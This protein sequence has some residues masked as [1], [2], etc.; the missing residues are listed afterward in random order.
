MLIYFQM[1]KLEINKYNVNFKLLHFFKVV[2]GNMQMIRFWVIKS[3][4]L[5]FNLYLSLYFF[6]YD[7]LLLLSSKI[8]LVFFFLK[9]QAQPNAVNL[10]TFSAAIFTQKAI[11]L[12]PCILVVLLL[13]QVLDS[14]QMNIHQ[15]ERQESDT[16]SLGAWNH[17]VKLSLAATVCS[18]YQSQWPTQGTDAF[19]S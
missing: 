6:N 13:L 3:Y 10:M 4:S 1:S 18:W 8:R 15:S 11:L 17:L 14:L 5:L 9:E 2:K 19:K 16:I 7:H 12:S